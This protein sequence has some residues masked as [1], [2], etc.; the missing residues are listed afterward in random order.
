MLR[1]RHCPRFKG[2]LYQRPS[3]I[4]SGRWLSNFCSFVDEFNEAES[5]HYEPDFGLTSSLETRYD[6]IMYPWKSI[7]FSVIVGSSALGHE[8]RWLGFSKHLESVCNTM[9]WPVGSRNDL[10]LLE[11]NYKHIQA[12]AY[13]IHNQLLSFSVY[14]FSPDDARNPWQAISAL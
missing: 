14:V 13:V 6:F 5:M 1:I 8:L 4:I 10:Q 11:N 9:P 12:A 2:T 7:A 3:P